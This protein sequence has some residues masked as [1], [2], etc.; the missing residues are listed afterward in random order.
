MSLTNCWLLGD[1]VLLMMPKGSSSVSQTFLL[2]TPR[3]SR[4]CEPV[5]SRKEEAVLGLALVK[6]GPRMFAFQSSQGQPPF[7]P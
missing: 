1:A 7:K 2:M 3:G 4:L 5:A 6:S